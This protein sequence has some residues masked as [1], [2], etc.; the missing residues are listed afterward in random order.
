MLFADCLLKRWLVLPAFMCSL[1]LGCSHKAPPAAALA[2]TAQSDDS[3]S[4]NPDPCSLLEPKEV[5]A[6]LGAPLAVPPFEPVRT[7]SPM[8]MVNNAPT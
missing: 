8:R 6:V 5:E 3:G 4:N 7:A 1:V 2:P